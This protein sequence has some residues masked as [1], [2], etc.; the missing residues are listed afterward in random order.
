MSEKDKKSNFKLPRY[1]KLAKGSMWFDIDSKDSSGVKLYSFNEVFV[2]RG[3]LETDRGIQKDKFDNQNPITYGFV[4][5]TLPW[6][7]D[8]TKIPP[9][10][11]SRIITAYKNG[12]L[13]EADPNNPPKP[14]APEP[15]KEFAVDKMGDRIFIG[16]NKEMYKKLMN[17]KSDEIKK[18][19]VDSPKVEKT[20]DNLLDLLDYEKKG[21]NMFS[22]PRAE[23]L[24]LISSKL[25]E[26]GP[27]MSAIRKND[28]D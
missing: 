12:V 15:K 18:F 25:K 14:K 11:L 13:E 24:D 3:K 20:R 7:T 16:K 6:Y 17:L 9:E 8:T 4:E 21:Y 23:I 28:L 2:G 5:Q 19:I 26:Y 27:S 22:R 1:L 10:K